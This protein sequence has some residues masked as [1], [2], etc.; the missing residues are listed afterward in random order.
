MYRLD[1]PASNHDKLLWHQLRKRG[2]EEKDIPKDLQN[3]P[4]K[5][6]KKGP[7]GAIVVRR[8]TG[9]QNNAALRVVKKFEA[10]VGGKEEVLEKLEAV[11]DTLN[12][13]QLRLLELLRV[14][15]KKSLAHLLADAQVEPASVMGAYARG[16]VELG[17]VNA[18]IEAHRNLPTVIKELYKHA[19]SDKGLCD[20]C[21][22]AGKL[23]SKATAQEDTKLC[24]FCEGTGVKDSSKL[25][26]FAL[27]KLLDITKQ[28]GTDGPSVQ[29]TTNVGVKVEG[30]GKGSVFGKV[31][32]A[33]DEVLYRKQRP[34][35]VV[36]AEIVP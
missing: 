29:V 11:K 13:D 5:K 25:K 3:L 26:Q 32:A 17:K 36:E 34:A 24:M 1:G 4:V 9:L 7:I 18:A 23:H 19:L 16:C 33:S 27:S 2:M 31:L 35:D 15:G 20:A 10:N 12:K 28:T 8:M 14:P 6:S 21:A 22:G 30:G